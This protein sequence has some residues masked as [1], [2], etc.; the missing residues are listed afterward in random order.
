MSSSDFTTTITPPAVSTIRLS[1]TRMEGGIHELTQL[2]SDLERSTVQIGIFRGDG[3][4]E[5]ELDMIR[6]ELD[7]QQKT[8][9]NG[10]EEIDLLYKH[11][12]ETQVVSEIYQEVERE[13]EVEIDRVV[14]DLVDEY[15]KE[16]IPDK[17]VEEVKKN[18]AALDT[19]RVEL[20]NS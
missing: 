13:V 4:F 2:L 8:Q 7:E 16:L 5:R 19:V 14:S 11:L 20:Y 15:L 12:V 9:R 18:K 10:L 17:L 3:T 6:R 1:L